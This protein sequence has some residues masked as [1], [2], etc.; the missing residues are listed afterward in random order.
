[1]GIRSQGDPAQSYND[2][3]GETVN[4]VAAASPSPVPSGDG[5]AASGG[6][7]TTYTDPTGSY[8]SHTFNSS[9]TFTV[10]TSPPGPS[11]D[12]QFLVQGGG[13]GCK[14]EIAGNRHA[15]SGAGGL[16]YGPAGPLIQDDFAITIGAGGNEANGSNSVFGGV[17]PAGQ[18]ALGGGAGGAGDSDPNCRGANGGCGGGGWYTG[19]GVKGDAT[20]PTNSPGLPGITSIGYDG[21]P[22]AGSPEY[23]GGGGG[24][25]SVAPGQG[26]NNG[27]GTSNVYRYGPTNAQTYGAGGEA[28]DFPSTNRN[29]N[30]TANKGD[31]ASGYATGGSGIVVIRYKL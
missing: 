16:I 21:A 12:A 26:T 13:G 19:P 3:F 17:G 1:M 24:T 15:G 11:Y 20:Q 22:G 31:G 5:M 28:S 29:A 23:G 2:V 30:G 27:T 8:K 14:D 25:G 7:T 9:G 18:T 6:T 10:T 4:P